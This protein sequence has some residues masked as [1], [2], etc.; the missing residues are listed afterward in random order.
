MSAV[1]FRFSGLPVCGAEPWARSSV[2]PDAVT[3]PTCRDTAVYAHL[4]AS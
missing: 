2:S 1:H 4:A 3:C